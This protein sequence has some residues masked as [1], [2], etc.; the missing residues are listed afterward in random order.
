MSVAS[1]GTLPGLLV[2][3]IAGDGALLLTWHLLLLLA[4]LVAL[5]A[6][7]GRKRHPVVGAVAVITCVVNTLILV[8][9]FY[10]LHSWV[11]HRGD[12][13]LAWDFDPFYG[14]VALY[15]SLL[16]IGVLCG[17][18]GVVLHAG[19]GDSV[20]RRLSDLAPLGFAIL[21]AFLTVRIP[22]VVQ[23]WIDHFP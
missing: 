1:G 14:G 7:Y 9:W 8:G 4:T 20:S 22:F 18:S 6:G 2:E 10:H 19:R 17:V 5:L 23:G 13:V 15:G 16:S 12:A 21:L 3:E 11:Y